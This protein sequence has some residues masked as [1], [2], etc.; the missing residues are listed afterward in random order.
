MLDYSVLQRGL[1][2]MPRVTKNEEIKAKEKEVM[3]KVKKEFGFTRKKDFL[4]YA[5]TKDDV[6]FSFFCMT[7]DMEEIKRLRDIEFGG[8]AS[9]I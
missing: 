9:A 8:V 2:D 5:K 6:D 4:E 7:L 1:L 3:K